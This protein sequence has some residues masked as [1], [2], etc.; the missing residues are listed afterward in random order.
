MKV[1]Q[2][3]WQK[4]NSNILT[5]L[6]EQQKNSFTS[7][8]FCSISRLPHTFYIF[9]CLFVCLFICIFFRKNIHLVLSSSSAKLLVCLFAHPQWKRQIGENSHE[10]VIWH[11]CTIWVEKKEQERERQKMREKAKTDKQRKE[12]I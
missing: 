5:R 10:T 1:R 4:V 2:K 9:I 6:R 12:N 8:G 3:N 7:K 11:A